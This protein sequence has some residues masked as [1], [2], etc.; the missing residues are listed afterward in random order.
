MRVNVCL[1]LLLLLAFLVLIGCTACDPNSGATIDLTRNMEVL[2]Y[3][4]GWE[5]QEHYEVVDFAD[6]THV[7]A[8]LLFVATD[9]GTVSV[10]LDDESGQIGSAMVD[11]PDDADVSF[12]SWDTECTYV[13]RITATEDSDAVLTLTEVE[14]ER[15][16]YFSMSQGN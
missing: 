5:A 12:F 15:K 16:M 6:D 13:V 8:H 11:I 4:L 14:T 10:S 1:A 2:A 9:H 3:T 7:L